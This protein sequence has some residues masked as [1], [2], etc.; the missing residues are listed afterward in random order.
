MALIQFRMF[1]IIMSLDIQLLEVVIGT[2]NPG[3]SLR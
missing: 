2:G 1:M 3:V